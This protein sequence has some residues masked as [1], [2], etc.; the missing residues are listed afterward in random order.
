MHGLDLFDYGARH[1]DAA[2]SRWW[3]VDALA[4]KYY[5]VSPYAYTA[6]NPVRYIDP[7]GM[8]YDDPPQNW[9]IPLRPKYEYGND[10]LKNS[11]TF[12]NNVSTD[13][14]NTGISI[15]NT[16][17]NA[18]QTLY[19]EGVSGLVNSEITGLKNTGNA[20]ANEVNYTLTTPIGE[21]MQGFK[22]PATW[23]AGAAFGA[24]LF[25][26]GAVTNLGKG[27]RATNAGA[28]SV[29]SATRGTANAIEGVVVH[30]NSLK[31]MKPTWGYKLYSNDGTFLKNGITSKVI[32]ETR[33]TKSFM[34]DKYM[35]PVK[36]FPNRLEAWQWEY[37][38]NQ[39]L[40]GPLN[41]N[42]H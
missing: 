3:G 29:V 11:L 31:S 32:P 28:K 41:K 22:N 14:L 35:V 8:W 37:Q 34:S 38:Q 4:E 40:R 16:P 30:G 21:Q 12:V 33:Y 24:T 7:N 13:I 17:I 36:Q 18:A 19:K 42:M 2:I 39:I 27:A 10:L 5:S 1:Y 25:A 26:G 9:L 15:I 6:N 20:I 23:E